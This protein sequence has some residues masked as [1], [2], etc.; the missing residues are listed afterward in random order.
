[1]KRM[2]VSFRV[3]VLVCGLALAALACE[4]GLGGPTPPASPIPVS[5]E[6]AGE[7]EQL[8]D[9]A[10]ANAENGEVSVTMTEAQVTSY[11]ALKLAEEPDSPFEDVQIFLRDGKITMQ[12]QAIAGDMRVPAHIVLG[13]TPSTDGPV[14]IAIEEADFGPVPVPESIL[15]DISDG[16]NDLIVG[17]LG[18]Q[19]AD[20]SITSIV[21]ADG[22][23][24]VSG[25]V[26]Q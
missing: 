4:M 26:N 25:T 18:N 1:M 13:V 23:M 9:Q 14:S 17:Q 22:Q 10:M 8:W 7:L 15:E 19:T 12:A 6:A 21:I 3:G 5:T 16:L 11:V 2:L 20:F 24:A